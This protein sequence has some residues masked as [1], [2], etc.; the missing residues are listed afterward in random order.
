MLDDRRLPSA[1]D[2]LNNFL[3]YTRH[4]VRVRVVCYGRYHGD[5]LARLSRR[6]ELEVHSQAKTTVLGGHEQLEATLRIVEASEQ[7]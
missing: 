1:G 5:L 4:A 2:A 7:R 3:G 6:R